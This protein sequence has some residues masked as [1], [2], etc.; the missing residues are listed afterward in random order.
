MQ[1]YQKE[2]SQVLAETGAL[3]FAPGLTL[4]DGRPTPY[5]VNM[6]LF[7]TGRLAA[8]IGSYLA[9]LTVDRGLSDGLDVVVGPSYKGSALAVATTQ[10]LWTNHGLDV[11]FDYDRKEAKSHGEARGR[12]N[13]FV[14]N[15]FFNGAKV[16]IVDDVGTSMGTKYD[17]IDLIAAESQAGGYV[18]TLAGVVLAVDREQTTA[19]YDETGRAV[20]GIKGEDAMG[21]FVEKTGLPVYSLAPIRQV[22]RYLASERIPVT[23]NNQKQPIDKA[24]LAGFETYMDTYGVPEKQD[25]E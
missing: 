20:E 9:G 11:M 6:G 7:R 4:K 18:L 25:G 1:A 23:V 12:Q 22:V 8:R 24:T 3:F 5:F 13:M 15:A 2:F 21:R 10:A 17:L 14:T 16:L 19:V